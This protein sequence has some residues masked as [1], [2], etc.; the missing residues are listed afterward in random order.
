MF[1][2]VPSDCS[3]RVPVRMRMPS[4]TSVTKIIPSAIVGTIV[5]RSFRRVENKFITRANGNGNWP[6]RVPKNA[7]IHLVIPV[8][9]TCYY[10]EMAK[11][12]LHPRVFFQYHIKVRLRS[13]FD[14]SCSV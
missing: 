6:A 7:P 12:P 11:Q 14:L 3:P 8:M 4:V 10:L 13:G 1:S 9:C 5:R 2:P